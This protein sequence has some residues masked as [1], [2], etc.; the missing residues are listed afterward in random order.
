MAL[1]VMS[2]WRAKGRI[3]ADLEWTRLTPWRQPIAQMFDNTTRGNPFSKFHTID[4]AHTDEKPNAGA[5]Y[6]AGWLAAPHHA[7]VSLLRTSGHGPGIHRITLRSDTETI[8]FERTACDCMTLRSTNGRERKYN[9]QDLEL[10]T[11]M[12]EELAVVG[13]DAAFESAFLRARELIRDYK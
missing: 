7:K 3:V 11:L 12:N 6:V 8:E 2:E 1:D 4:V 13:R 5:L 9:F 10:H